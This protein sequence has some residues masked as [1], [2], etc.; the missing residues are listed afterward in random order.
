[1]DAS[2]LYL[3]ACARGD[4]RSGYYNRNVKVESGDGPV[5]VR[6]PATGSES[7]DLTMWPEHAVLD[8][9]QPYVTAAPQ[10]LHAQSDP[11]F[12]IHE[13]IAGTSVDEM[14]PA[15][16][17]LP[18]EV[19]EDIGTLFAQMLRVPNS[20]LPEPPPS[21]PRTVTPTGSLR[22]CCD[23]YAPSGATSTTRPSGSTRNWV[24]P[25]TRVPFSRRRPGRCRPGRSACCTPISTVRT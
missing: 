14:S 20:A 24:S 15:G 9:I 17:R 2:A 12:Q 4:A 5:M 11:A 21:G 8:A 18:L 10:L 16:T 19:L 3:E 22:C 7:M 1:M 25:K 13:F 23:W 6:I